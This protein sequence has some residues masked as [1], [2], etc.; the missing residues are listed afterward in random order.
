MGGKSG[1][2]GKGKGGITKHEIMKKSI[3]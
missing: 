1:K 2:A 3:R